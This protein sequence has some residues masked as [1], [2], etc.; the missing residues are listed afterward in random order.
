MET[1]TE[2]NFGTPGS[3]HEKGHRFNNNTLVTK[4]KDKWA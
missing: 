4:S 2:Q 1:I 3:I